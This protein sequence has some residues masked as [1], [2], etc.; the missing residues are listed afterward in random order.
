MMKQRLKAIKCK[1]KKI[2]KYDIDYSKLTNCIKRTNKIVFNGYNFLRY[3]IL[4][5]IENNLEFPI[6]DSKF[7][8]YVFKLLCIKSRGPKCKTS[9][10]ILENLRNNFLKENDIELFDCTNLSFLLNGEYTKIETSFTNN[11]LMNFHKYL[12]Q[13]VNEISEIPK[14]IR[15]SRAEYLNM[16]KDEKIKYKQYKEQL[17]KDRKEIFTELSVVKSDLINLNLK[18]DSK[19]HALIQEIRSNILP[20]CTSETLID[21]VKTE[22]FKYLKSMILMNRILEDKNLKMFQPIPLRT[23]ICDKYVTIDT[24]ALKDIFTDT[25]K[26][27]KI[28]NDVFWNK[29][30]DINPN[31]FKIKNHVFNDMICTDGTAVS[32][33]FI[34]KDDMDKKVVQHQK[35]SGASAKSRR[36]IKSMNPDELAKYNEDKEQKRMDKIK[37]DKERLK[38]QREEFKKL[39][40]E[41]QKE[42]RKKNKVI[43]NYFEDAV[44][45]ENILNH[46]KEQRMKNKIVVCDPGRRSILTMLGRRINKK[47]KNSKNCVEM[48]NYRSRR[49][50][51]DTK[52]KKCTRLRQNKYNKWIGSKGNEMCKT[53][54]KTTYL[55]EFKYYLKNKYELL[56]NVE[57]NLMDYNNAIN[58]L[59]WHSYINKKRHE[60]KIIN[61]IIGKYGKDATIVIGDWSCGSVLGGL[62]TPRN[63]IKRELDKNFEV[64]LIDEF[65]TSK[66]N[67]KTNEEMN[68]LIIN[69]IMND[70]KESHE[71]YSVFTYKMSK[72]KL[73][74]INRDYNAVLNIENI[75]NS[76]LDVG[77]RP[78]KFRRESKEIKP[79][80]T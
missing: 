47:C 66:I 46:L 10:K 24:S 33:I 56:R 48:Y 4:Y 65:N 28:N 38:Q 57:N 23:D 50:F 41:E 62:S 73:G 70:E 1:F 26:G 11:I 64:Y 15:K 37:A 31:K 60:S 55:S 54:S 5:H 72:G 27:V 80:N 68:K 39:P 44:K 43:I 67:Y 12:F 76:L 17:K 14:I 58:K 75:V 29:Y 35:M 53:K 9:N 19:Y 78:E 34:H 79:T 21:D 7:L 22:P 18:S 25:K 45:D 77:V 3:C 49:R 40:K 32:I 74:C 36:L 69:K 20:E 13:Y 8:R 59:K 61:E 52:R 51:K 42:L 16:T 63:G 2:Q 6:I 30:F 71:L